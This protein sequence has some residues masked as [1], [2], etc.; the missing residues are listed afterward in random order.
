M[1]H[2]FNSP[3]HDG[4]QRLTDRLMDYAEKAEDTLMKKDRFKFF[5]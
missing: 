3:N 4:F 2:K 5:L 1:L